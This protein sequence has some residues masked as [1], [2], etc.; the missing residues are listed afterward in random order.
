MA[1]HHEHEHYRE[2]DDERIT[3]PM[4]SFATG[5]VLTGALIALVGIAVAF[6]VPLLLA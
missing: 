6:G 3:S 1:D 5:Q 4:Q 2:F